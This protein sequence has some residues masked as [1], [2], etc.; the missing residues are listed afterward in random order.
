[1]KTSEKRESLVL[2][3]KENVLNDEQINFL[4]EIIAKEKNKR[5]ILRIIGYTE[6]MM[7]K[8]DTAWPEPLRNKILEAGCNPRNFVY[9]Y[10]EKSFGELLNVAEKLGEKVCD[11]FTIW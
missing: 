4:Y 2:A 1:M 7:R 9:D 5:D 8:I 10:N 11:T 3:I 6:E